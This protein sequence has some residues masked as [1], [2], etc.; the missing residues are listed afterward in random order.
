MPVIAAV[1]KLRNDTAANWTSANPVLELGEPGVENDTGKFK[2]GDG[3]TSWNGLEYTIG[4]T[5]PQGEQGPQGA[6]GPQGIQGD[7]GPEGPQGPQGIQGDTGPE[8][9]QGPQGPQGIQG[10]TGPAGADGADGATGPQGIQGETGPAGAD[11]ATGPQGPQG[12]QGETGPQ[13]PQGPQG[14]QGETG[15]QGIQGIQGET[16]PAGADGQGVPTGGTT[17]QVLAKASDTDYDTEWVAPA[18]GGGAVYTLCKAKGNTS[19]ASVA[20]NEAAISWASPAIN[21]GADVSV[22]GS[23]I[24]INTTGTYKFTVTLRTASN[25]RTELFVKTYIN[26]GGG[27]TEDADE[28]VSDYVARDSDQNTGAVTLITALNLAATNTVEFRGEG[29]CD[30]TCTMLDAGTILL[31]ERVA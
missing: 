19:S 25:N 14:I 24:T 8:G 21:T 18:G 22:S 31:V 26:T 29:D 4:A 13:G 20:N 6:T 17:G 30:G 28:L 27:L 7:T 9:P 2:V 23:V 15:P 10:D 12:V 16:G 1:I 5:G 11:G 3:V